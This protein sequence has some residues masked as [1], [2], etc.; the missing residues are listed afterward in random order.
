MKKILVAAIVL[1]AAA[2]LARADIPHG[3][4]ADDFD[5]KS[6]N[7][8]EAEDMYSSLPGPDQAG[9]SLRTQA[10]SYRVKRSDDG[11]EQTICERISFFIVK[12]PTEYH[13][14]QEKS[15]SGKPLPV[16]HPLRRMG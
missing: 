6:F 5:S 10:S 4:A 15:K 1:F 2:P 14:T 9:D 13:C 16:F 7:G 3:P 12:K 11:L 8:Q